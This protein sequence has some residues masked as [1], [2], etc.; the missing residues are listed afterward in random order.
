MSPCGSQRRRVCYRDHTKRFAVV[1]AEPRGE[2]ET[3]AEVVQERDNHSE[4]GGNELVDRPVVENT[5]EVFEV[6][7][8]M[9]RDVVLE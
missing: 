6:G 5:S 9:G 8:G 4:A 3:V 7:L 1:L 2:N